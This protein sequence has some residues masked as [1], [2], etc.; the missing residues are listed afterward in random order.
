MSRSLPQ[1]FYAVNYLWEAQLLPITGFLHTGKLVAI[2]NFMEK[3]IELF[4]GID[5]GQTHTKA[6]IADSSGNILGFGLGG[7]IDHG[8]LPDSNA[9][10]KTAISN[11]I[12]S[13]LEN[14]GLQTDDVKFTSIYFGLTGGA[15][16]KE[17]TVRTLV[18]AKTLEVGHDALTAL[19]GGTAG[20]PGIVVVA[21]T[22]SIVFGMNQKGETARAGGLGFLFS[23][24]G[25]G[26][27][28]AKET[29]G[30]AIKEQDGAIKNYGLEK[31]VLKFFDVS[32]IRHLTNAFY[33]NEISRDK[34][35][36]FAENVLAEASRSNKFLI[37]LM[38]KGI[39]ELVANVRG[40]ERKLKF[41][42][43]YKVCGAGGL[44]QHPFF[45]ENFKQELTAALPAARFIQPA[46]SPA[47]GAL[48]LAYR[49]AGVPI[50][51]TILANL[52]N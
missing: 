14:G 26:F 41:R 17:A 38:I 20:D 47:V 50:S 19:I 1:P 31:I 18:K 25:S 6:V 8:K 28:L 39:H 2:D 51:K 30:A 15:D 44:F 11:S 10:L 40:T 3:T 22:G 23:D 48:L 34:I 35:A 21:G 49:N 32:E 36:I 43:N 7:A 9:K 37:E 45:R 16:H 4:A 5:G 46:F 33:N 24:G 12:D 29:I 27:W 42:T 52:K 13:A